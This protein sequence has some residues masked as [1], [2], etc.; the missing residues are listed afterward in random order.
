MPTDHTIFKLASLNIEAMR[1]VHRF[2][3]FLQAYH[4]DVLCLQELPEDLIPQLAEA[5][6]MPHHA[7]APMSD[8]HH[9][10]RP[11]II[12]QGIFSRTPLASV[13]VIPYAGNGNGRSRFNNGSPAEKHATALYSLLVADTATGR[14]NFRV[15]TTHFLWTP[16]GSADDLQRAAVETLLHHTAGLGEHLL[17]GDFNAPRGGEIASRLQAAYTD[18]IPAHYSC[19]L[20]KSLH[21]A[22]TSLP[23][24]MVDYLFTTPAYTANNVQLHAGVSDHMAI[25]GEFVAG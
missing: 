10:E 19:S 18:T 17:C 11:A 9:F 6:E 22:G 2:V 4:P 5:L 8:N 7:F 23:D 24:Y 20:D 21:R 13:R 14:R 25:T 16:D 3:P 12:G 15:A 1:H